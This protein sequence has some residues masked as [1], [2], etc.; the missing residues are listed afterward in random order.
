M[1]LYSTDHNDTEMQSAVELVTGVTHPVVEHTT[2]YFITIQDE[3]H[4]SHTKQHEGSYPAKPS[5]RHQKELELFKEFKGKPDQE[6]WVPEWTM[7][8]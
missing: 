1:C 4:T 7:V 5:K 8:Y 6:S 3:R 2:D